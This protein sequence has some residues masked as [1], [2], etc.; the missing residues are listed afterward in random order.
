MTH[1]VGKAWEILHEEHQHTIIKTFR[2]TGL[3]LNPNGS[4]DTE[5]KIRDLPGIKVGDWTR[6]DLIIISGKNP[7]SCGNTS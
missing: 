6:T 4:E 3:S 2:Q 7:N 1:W 5:L